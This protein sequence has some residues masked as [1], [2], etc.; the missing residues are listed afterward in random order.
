M[1]LKSTELEL[2]REMIPT[3]DHDRWRLS[4]STCVTA[5]NDKLNFCGFHC[6]ARR[7]CNIYY[8]MR[9]GIYGRKKL[10]L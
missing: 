8:D 1:Q 9:Y 2:L 6:L 5:L 10:T 3:I 4:R 7:E